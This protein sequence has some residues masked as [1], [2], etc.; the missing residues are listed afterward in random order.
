[1]RVRIPLRVNSRIAQPVER[2]AKTVSLTAVI[3]FSYSTVNVMFERDGKTLRECI[4]ELTDDSPDV[5]AAA[6]E[7]IMMMEFG[8]PHPRATL[9]DVD[10]DEGMAFGE[11]VRRILGDS[12]FPTAEIAPK[13][14]ALYRSVKG[15]DICAMLMRVLH[16]GSDPKRN[17]ANIAGLI[18]FYVGPAAKELLPELIAMIEAGPEEAEARFAAEVVASMGAAGAPATEAFFLGLHEAGADFDLKYEGRTVWNVF[19]RALAGLAEHDEQLITRLVGLARDDEDTR[20]GA[21]ITLQEIGPRAKQAIPVL[22]ELIGNSQDAYL[23]LDA[24]RAIDPDDRANIRRDLLGQ[25]TTCEVYSRSSLVHRLRELGYSDRVIANEISIAPLTD[26]D[27]DVD[28]PFYGE[29]F[30]DSDDRDGDEINGVNLTLELAQLIRNLVAEDKLTRRIAS[31]TLLERSHGSPAKNEVMQEENEREFRDDLSTLLQNP[32]FPTGEVLGAIVKR[33]G[34]IHREYQERCKRTDSMAWMMQHDALTVGMGMA[35]VIENCGPGGAAVLGQ[36]AELLENDSD[37]H[38]LSRTAARAM[39]SIGSPAC[40]I[41]DSLLNNQLRRGVREWP[42]PRYEFIGK[43]A[44]TQRQLTR[45]MQIVEHGKGQRR[46]A[47]V[48]M[49]ETLGPRAAAARDLLLKVA[50]TPDGALRSSIIS[51]LAAVAGNDPAV[52]TRLLHGSRDADEDARGAAARALGY[53]SEPTEEMIDR[54]F[55]LSQDESW[56]VRAEAILSLGTLNYR[57]T[58]V[59]ARAMELLDDTIGHDFTVSERAVE[60]LGKLGDAAAPAVERLTEMLEDDEGTNFEVV[61]ALGSIGP[62]AIAA[63]DR[64]RILRMCHIDRRGEIEQAIRAIRQ[65]NSG[66]DTGGRVSGQ[67]KG[68]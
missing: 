45:V 30:D 27:A 61:A 46:E 64:L 35:Q 50:I 10:W 38:M 32:D 33:F 8:L 15:V 65:E 39:L 21:I 7:A 3:R 60:A 67:R 41:M 26:P 19:A 17:V 34:E 4:L 22:V 62:A 40:A 28:D 43:H 56:Y 57:P 58:D 53:V 68:P 13:L 36:L 23:A 2:R 48:T 1:L 24:L 59:C 20:P 66:P 42:N 12:D 11:S 63:L 25:L 14:L 47:A 5:R 55:D 54:L 49:L 37:D 52:L 18:L 44:L 9:M 16:K 51:A 29:D 31:N 6:A